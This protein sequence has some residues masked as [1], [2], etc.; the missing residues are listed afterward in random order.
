[1]KTNL[2]TDFDV[3]CYIRNH[4]E[5]QNAKSQ[6]AEEKLD[7]NEISNIFC[8]YRSPDGLSCAIGCLIEDKHYSAG[9]EKNDVYDMSVRAAIVKS[10]PN[11]ELNEELLADLQHIHDVVS[12]EKWKNHLAI[13]SN[14]FNS[15]GSYLRNG[16]EE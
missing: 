2:L 16:E 7:V 15:V 6:L 12:V 4:L 5:T 9:L 14:N 10:I 13:L 11:W 1:M 3:F 8:A